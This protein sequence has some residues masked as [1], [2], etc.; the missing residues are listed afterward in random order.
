MSASQAASASLHPSCPALASSRLYLAIDCGGT[1]AAA[2]I[3][4]GSGEVLGR[5][6]GGAA[7]YADVGTAAF[8]QSVRAA[9][10]AAV[11][12]IRIDNAAAA[13]AASEVMTEK[14][15]RWIEHSRAWK[16]GQQASAQA[17]TSQIS[18]TSEP[19][20]QAGFIFE[21]A[22]LAIAGVDAASD[23]VRISPH[24]SRL[25]CLPHPSA[26][27]IVANDTSLLAAP[28]HD[29]A[30]S[31]PRLRTGVVTI[32]GTGSIVMAYRQEEAHGSSTLR[33]L[34]RAGG[35]GWLLGD[36][37]S[38][39]AVGRDA[40]RKIIQQADR[41][42]IQ[43]DYAAE[44]AAKDSEHLF[45]D[46]SRRD[47]QVHGDAREEV[48][49]ETPERSLRLGQMSHLLR[50][51]ILQAWN[52]SSTDELFNAVYS[53]EAPVTSTPAP[54]PP[55]A[56]P[57]P[58]SSSTADGYQDQ[59]K[60]AAHVDA[61]LNLDAR[62]PS[63][64]LLPPDAPGPDVPN[65]IPSPVPP[66]S[67]SRPAT[68]ASSSSSVFGENEG[69]REDDTEPVRPPE[70]LSNGR[71]DRS[72]H[73]RTAYGGP[74]QVHRTTVPPPHTRRRRQ[75]RRASWA[76]ASTASPRSPR[77]SSTSPSTMT[78]VSRSRSCGTRHASSHCRSS[79]S[80]SPTAPTGKRATA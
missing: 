30:A 74:K 29:A 77:S 70:Q 55:A 36:E 10:D 57:A 5:G 76:S 47:V 4:S 61:A 38:G 37:G 17:S 2:A 52:L 50:D 27:L 26:R 11:R 23:V 72:S 73:Q 32:A 79:T 41:E 33:T 1:K 56:A 20:Q 78:T 34:G 31:D 68:P 7:N 28:V 25:L 24:L 9:V 15:R 67:T 40:V 14:R 8:L 65:R 53:N 39:F 43:R 46:G 71:G 18:A 58:A 42:R 45:R 51:R 59:A 54:G 48:L 19:E 21:A 75:T 66:L 12:S 64:M 62:L 60:L 16:M 22:W 49:M 6:L 3:A 80:S 63:K 44:Q 69:Q 35:F 13:G